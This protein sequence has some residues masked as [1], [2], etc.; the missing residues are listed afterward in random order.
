MNLADCSTEANVE[1][2]QAN[3]GFWLVSSF[4]ID[5][6]DMM[7][8]TLDSDGT[9]SVYRYKTTAAEVFQIQSSRTNTWCL[10]NH[11]VSYTGFTTSIS[12]PSAVNYVASALT[13]TFDYNQLNADET[14]TTSIRIKNDAG[15]NVE[16][17][18]I[19]KFYNV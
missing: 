3:G 15:L 1:L 19:V 17:S 9:L 12:V 14:V 7:P 16:K 2:D 4:T 13:I 5:E 10:D 8:L 18:L 11:P 6:P